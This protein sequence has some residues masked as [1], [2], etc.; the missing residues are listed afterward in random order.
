MNVAISGQAGLA[1]LFEG[2]KIHSLHRHAPDELV[3]R[4]PGSLRL[5]LAGIQDV[6]VFEDIDR[7]RA[8]IELR[9]ASNRADGLHLALYL[10]DS[11]LS[12]GARAEVAQELEELLSDRC[13]ADYVEAVLWSH[14]LPP[15][16]DLEGG[17]RIA[18]QNSTRAFDLLIRFERAQ[19]WIDL[20]WTS[21]KEIPDE[22]F[23]TSESRDLARAMAVRR[24][25]FPIVVKGISEGRSTEEM[26]LQLL[27]RPEARDV[28]NLSDIAGAWL[29]QLQLAQSSEPIE[30]PKNRYLSVVA[31]PEQPAIRPP[32]KPS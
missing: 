3:E 11:T 25:L 8:E 16:G 31:E 2:E 12:D 27:S 4:Q 23:G 6:E 20:A 29:A 7:K 24:G 32:K 28:P 1:L 17:E 22:V 10:L 15:D 19:P 5:L 30:W 14:P 18:A 13:V 9:L 26:N 21:W